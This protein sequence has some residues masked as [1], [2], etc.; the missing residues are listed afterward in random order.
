[1]PQYPNRSDLRTQAPMASKG[2]NY[3]TAKAQLDAQG[4]QPPANL[5]GME[6]GQIPTL[7]DPSVMP[8]Q[9]ITAGLPSG[10]GPG[11]EALSAASFG[12]MELSVLRQIYLKFPNEDLRRMIEW[13]ESNLG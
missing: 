6:P 4:A 11:P 1:M 10:P 8:Q 3:G 7:S 2:Q 12:P 13:T 5:T 9:P